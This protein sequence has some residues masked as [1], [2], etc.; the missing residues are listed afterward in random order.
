M[1]PDLSIIFVNYNCAATIFECIASVRQHTSRSYEIVVVDNGSRPEELLLLRKSEEIRIIATGANLGFGRA[2]NRGA[3]EARGKWLVLLNPDTLLV[4]DA[5]SHLTAHLEAVP[6]CAM[7]VPKLIRED[8]T[9]QH[10][11]NLPEALPWEFAKTHYLQGLWYRAINLH[12]ILRY[13]LAQP[14]PVGCSVGACWVLSLERFLSL[15]G[16]DEDFFM[17]GEDTEFCDRL[18]A[19]GGSIQLLPWIQVRHFEG[20]TQR[21]NWSRYMLHRFQAFRIYIEKRYRGWQRIVA[22]L[23]WWEALLLRIGIGFIMLR[24]SARSRIQGYVSAT[25]TDYKSIKTSQRP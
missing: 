5:L 17:N 13:G 3:S 1:T 10:S 21:Q 8:G 22:R 19:T 24:G 25:K 12:H 14:W 6:E 4:S 11:W 20:L 7:T 9:F 23:L 18:R 2:C 16:F 15:G